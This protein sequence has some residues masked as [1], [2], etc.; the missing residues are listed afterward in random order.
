MA[1]V[2]RTLDQGW[3]FTQLGSPSP[4]RAMAKDEW[5]DVLQFPTTVHVELLKREKIP[6][7]V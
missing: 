3:A 4:E 1:S 2:Y 7:P 6:D 5:L